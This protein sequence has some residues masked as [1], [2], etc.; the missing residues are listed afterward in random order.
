MTPKEW[1]EKPIKSKTSPSLIGNWGLTRKRKVKSQPI[2][3]ESPREIIQHRTG[4]GTF[5]SYQLRFDIEGVPTCLTDKTIKTDTHYLTCTRGQVGAEPDPALTRFSAKQKKRSFLDT[6]YTWHMTRGTS[7]FIE[8][9]G[10][11]PVLREYQMALGGRDLGIPRTPHPGGDRPSA[12]FSFWVSSFRHGRGHSPR[13][14]TTF[15]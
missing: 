6:I 1:R 3:V 14:R 7:H 15:S 12:P 13:A 2:I 11:H 5:E 4:H 10:G 9:N 8:V